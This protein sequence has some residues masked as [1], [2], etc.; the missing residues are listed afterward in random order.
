[1][2]FNS[3]SLTSMQ[4]KQYDFET[5]RK[6]GQEGEALLDQWLSPSY[7]VLDVS[8]NLKYQQSGIDR[9]VTRSD[10]SIITVEY[11]LDIAARRTGNLFFETVSNDKAKIPG[12][13]WSSQAD[14][15]IFLIPQQE[16]LVFNPG[17][18]RALVWAL[19]KTLKEKSV[20]NKGYNTIG[21][22]TPLIQARE[23][24]FQT[25]TLYLEEL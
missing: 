16:I 8:D 15:W 25:K 12:W 2:A 5:Q 6:V 22:P 21:Y 24:A 17:K 9:I 11:K 14:Y 20:A 7:K 1:M 18:L 4:T 3:I 23:V 10:G 13:G 19:Q